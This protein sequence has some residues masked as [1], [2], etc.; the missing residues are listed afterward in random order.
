MD[1]IDEIH[2]LQT[3]ISSINSLLD[4]AKQFP[5]TNHFDVPRMKQDKEQWIKRVEE[6]KSQYQNSGMQK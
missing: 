3:K 2:D 4:L 5:N 6:L 1:T